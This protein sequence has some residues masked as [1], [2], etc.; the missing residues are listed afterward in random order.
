MFIDRFVQWMAS[1]PAPEIPDFPDEA[2]CQ[3][4]WGESRAAMMALA[5]R[6]PSATPAAAAAPDRA[7]TAD[8]YASL[9]C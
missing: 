1:Q 7:W 6:F 4:L 3:A 5:D 8:D 9:D 2:A